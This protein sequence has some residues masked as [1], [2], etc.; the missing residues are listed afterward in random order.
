[1]LFAAFAFIRAKRPKVIILENVEN[2]IK[3]F[4]AVFAEL[5][6][7]LQGLGYTCEH[8]VINTADHGLP[9][10]RPRVYLIALHG[11]IKNKLEWPSP[12]PMIPLHKLLDDSICALCVTPSFNATATR[13]INK[14]FATARARGVDPSRVPVVVDVDAGEHYG[15]VSGYNV[16]PCLTASRGKAGGFYVSTLDRKMNLEEAMHGLTVAPRNDSLRGSQKE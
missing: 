1:M 11:D 14:A 2:L 15:V 10:Q 12:I 13:Y 3:E 16:M 9:H 6:R 8:R 7:E 4:K 5:V